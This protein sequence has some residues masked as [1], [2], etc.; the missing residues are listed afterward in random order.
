MATLMG[1]RDEIPSIVGNDD[2]EVVVVCRS[3]ASDVINQGR[4]TLSR[5][6]RQEFRVGMAFLQCSEFIVLEPIAFVEDEN[7]LDT[8]GIDLAEDVFNGSDLRFVFI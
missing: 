5:P 3:D 6:R 4:D 8:L 2:F 1:D 7:T